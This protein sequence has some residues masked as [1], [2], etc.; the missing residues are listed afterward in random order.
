MTC[1]IISKGNEITQSHNEH[2]PPYPQIKEK[3]CKKIWELYQSGYNSFYLNCEYG[4]PLWSAEIIC[5]MKK[6]DDIKLHIVIPY[7]NQPLKWIEEN[8]DRYYNIHALSDDVHMICTGYYDGCYNDADEYMI[9]RSGLLLIYGE[10]DDNLY[11]AEYARKQ[12][13]GYFNVK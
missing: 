1:T 10:A 9:D 6:Y 4:I 7:E 12:G 5:E 11:G 3:L 2:E 8:R 13:V